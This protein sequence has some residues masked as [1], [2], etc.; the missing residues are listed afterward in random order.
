MIVRLEFTVSGEDDARDLARDLSQRFISPAGQLPV[1]RG[2]DSAS[3]SLISQAQYQ[4]DKILLE[5]LSYFL[6]S[7]AP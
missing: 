7:R 6:P 5:A 4:R 1:F 3:V 2:W